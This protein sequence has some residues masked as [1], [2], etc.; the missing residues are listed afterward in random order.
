METIH[1]GSF[2]SQPLL[3]PGIS[4]ADRLAYLRTQYLHAIML[5]I[6]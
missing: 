6:Q 4:G 2:F 5:S 3:C 1:N